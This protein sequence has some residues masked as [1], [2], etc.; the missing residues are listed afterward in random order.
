MFKQALSYDIGEVLKAI[1]MSQE[2][3]AV[4]TLLPITK[5]FSQSLFASILSPPRKNAQS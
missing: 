2:K 1:Y 3:V 4:A 5:L